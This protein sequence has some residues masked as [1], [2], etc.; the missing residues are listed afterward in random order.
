MLNQITT[1]TRAKEH[2]FLRS[3]KLILLVISSLFLIYF[4]LLGF[5]TIAAADT[6]ALKLNQIE[7]R[8]RITSIEKDY[9]TLSNNLNLEFA[10]ENGYTKPDKITY[11]KVERNNNVAYVK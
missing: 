7:I 6:R 2:P 1:I 10:L 4:Y 5:S 8:D 9:F 11:L 3:N